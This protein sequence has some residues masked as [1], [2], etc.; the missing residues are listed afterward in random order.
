MDPPALFQNRVC[1]R[2][3]DAALRGPAQLTMGPA[4]YFDAMNLGHAVA[5]ELAAAQDQA[6]GLADLPLRAALGDPCALA[7]RTTLTAVTT[8]TLRRAADGT[9]SFL[10][11]WRDPARVNHA[12]GAYQVMSRHL[13]AG[14]RRPG[15]AAGRLEPVAL[16]DPGVQR[17]TPRRLRRHGVLDY[18]QWPFARELAAAREAGTLRVHCVGLGVDPL[19][20]ATDLLTVAVFNSAVFDRLFRDLVTANTEG[21][22]VSEN[23]SAA[24]PFHRGYRGP[25]HRRRRADADP[26]GPRCSGWPGSTATPCSADPER[27]TPER[28]TP[29]M[30]APPREDAER[31]AGAGAGRAEG[32]S[33]AMPRDHPVPGPPPAGL[34]NALHPRGG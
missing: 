14:D 11:H 27:L 25:V 29:D 8:L 4:R 9:A 2:L 23:G 20:L 21:R 34:P 7:Q 19:T 10:L 17:G 31:G 13:P 30:R 12:G 6:A 15:R 28:L 1:Y 16:H 18:G 3:L 32:V 33:R 5:H 22:V 26:P 24:I